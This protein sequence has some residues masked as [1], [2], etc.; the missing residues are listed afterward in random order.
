MNNLTQLDATIPATAEDLARDLTTLATSPGNSPAP[1]L[2]TGAPV[3]Q[4][5]VITVNWEGTRVP[6]ALR[7]LDLE[8][9]DDMTGWV[10]TN[11][12]GRSFK[13]KP[14]RVKMGPENVPIMV[15]ALFGL[16]PERVDLAVEQFARRHRAARNFLPLFLVDSTDTLLLR[17]YGY[18]FEYF[19]PEVYS[20]EHMAD[21]F[22]RRF[23]QI[24]K[25]WRCDYL[26]DL[27]TPGYLDARIE[28]L[29]PYINPPA[30][31]TKRYD[32]RKR[33]GSAPRPAPT[34][35][36]ALK[37]DYH[38]SG[39]VSEPDTFVL[40]RILG[41]DLPPRH[42]VGQT[43]RNLRFLLENE[44]PLEGCEKRWII[45]R[46]VNPEQEAAIIALLEEFDQPYLSIPFLY[47]EYA[48]ADWDLE[49]FPDTP[50]F[51]RGRY[52]EM[53]SYDQLRAQAHL[54][55]LK[56]NYL[57]HNNGARNV[58]LRDGKDRA[59]WVL[60]W[61][62]NCFISAS[63]WAEITQTVTAQSYLKYFTVPMSRALDNADLLNTDYR[64][65]AEEE[66]QMLFRRDTTEEF[67]ETF[68]YG[69]RPKVELF[70]RL[71]IPGPWDTWPDDVWDLPRAAR[72]EDAGA[73][74]SAGWVARL[75]SGQGQLEVGQNVGL[76]SRG[77]ARISAIT[78][79]LDRLD[80]EALKLVYRPE[81]LTAYDEDKVKALADAE[82]G[83]SER[84]VHDRL[85]QEAELALQRGPYSVADK[86]AT[87]PSGDK[88]DYF[89]PAPYWWPN[90]A[91]PTG[92]P[93][94]FRDGLRIPGTRLY[95]PESDLYDRTRVQKLFD[96]S[97]TL[98]LAWLLTGK[99][100]YIRHAASLVRHWF[101]TEQTRMN[102]HLLYSQVRSQSPNDHGSK[103]GLIE[104]KDLYY[105]LDAVR[106]VERSGEF[107]VEDQ[108]AMRTWLSEYAEWLETSDQGM[109]EHA[110]Q[111]NHG[112]CLDL[113]KAAIAAFVND[114]E[115]L[116][117]IFRTSRERMLEQFKPD[118]LQPHEM[119]RTQTAHY[120]CFNL[121]NWINL[122]NLAEACGDRLWHFEAEDGRGLAAAF[123]WLLPRLA[124]TQWKYEQI[125]P[126]DRSRFLPLFYEA[127]G[128]APDTDEIE[129]T[130][131]AQ[132][133]PLF[134]PHDGIKPFWMLGKSP[135][136]R[137]G[138]RSWFDLAAGL[139]RL[140]VAA[141]E[142]V[143]PNAA[144]PQDVADVRALDKRLWGGF[145]QDARAGLEA[146][147]DDPATDPKEVNRAARS[148]ARW[149]FASGDMTAAL[150]AATTIENVGVLAERE[151]D[152]LRAYCLHTLGEGEASGEIVT[153]LLH[154][155]PRDISLNF[156]MANFAGASSAPAGTGA[157]HWV[158]GIYRRAGLADLVDADGAFAR[159]Q[160]GPEIPDPTV[161]IVSVILTIRAE[162]Q[163]ATTA[164]TSL[165]QQTWR[166]LDIIL[167]DQT[168]G[169]LDK[170]IT[171]EIASDDRVTVIAL[172]PDEPTFA[173]RN[174]A[175]DIAKGRYVTVHRADEWAHPEKLQRLVSLHKNDEPIVSIAQ[176]AMASE[177]GEFFAGWFP[178][179][180]F[181]APNPSSMMI[182]IDM[183]RALGGWDAVAD[184]LDTCLRWRIEKS[185]G[186]ASLKL[187]A[188][189]PPLSVTIT[190]G[191]PV[192]P[193]H[194]GFPAG[195]RRDE[196]RR[197][198][199]HAKAI[200]A[201]RI[202]P[203]ETPFVIPAMPPV[204]SIPSA[205]FD[206]VYVGDFAAGSIAVGEIQAF[207]ERTLATDEKA[208]LFHWTDK[209]IDRPDELEDGIADLIDTGR[210]TQ[211]STYEIVSTKL[212]VIC[213]P[214]LLRAPVD[215]VPNFQPETIAVLGGPEFIGVDT[216]DG[217]FRMTPTQAELEVI[218]D[219]S[220]QWMTL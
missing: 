48:R 157:A 179:F 84:Y 141:F 42:E 192:G 125:E 38:A 219:T 69:R 76:R 5:A 202:P 100:D 1:S 133:K 67:N 218:L 78:Q 47:E 132:G 61:D 196:L 109:D 124:R 155:F 12:P 204:A 193:T 56:N 118:G 55:R 128:R 142:M 170:A 24:W 123:G 137:S 164:F 21:Q 112:T 162:D 30:L 34:D 197:L 66:P 203:R 77:E 135:M 145:S 175:L 16:T 131:A 87:P 27:S 63:A 7:T 110:T 206:T 4:D 151:R 36:I 143:S 101:I 25:K 205:S 189:A 35:V 89:N 153:G 54:R 15:V 211:I 18:T 198:S 187:V 83:T 14:G 94:Q 144:P 65:D 201:D 29:D 122:C 86:G 113:Q 146:L 41:N 130:R 152:L 92:M 19:P 207:I 177:G 52:A 80:V 115:R 51:L 95:E 32:P 165:C 149:S 191:T 58:A 17:D 172:A 114:P 22:L 195:R 158:N 174:A 190:P 150:E 171:A 72:S 127:R 98:S 116:H 119:K 68:Y 97:T 75:F 160:T 180:S 181:V 33:R 134:F 200:R 173:A 31:N 182:P 166:A 183:V 140:E 104:M 44:P 106:L 212:L 3:P 85:I 213:H 62:G 129:L 28:D 194:I 50:F 184:N 96:D 188:A 91:T 99:I 167:V 64:P 117:D 43:L 185:F 209:H 138:S 20:S 8:P 168:D 186:V 217:K 37:A 210:L 73:T 6:A 102:P 154:Q 60:P 59:K 93:F 220:F 10:D 46:V 178:E 156:A 161:P 103:S 90:P 9:E 81:T 120:C 82:D 70:Y 49:S 23:R 169:H 199:R 57:I 208:G 216:M 13:P 147:R 53:N 2:A 74:G 40:Y 39:L 159:Y 121:Q 88:Q 79:M 71:G 11:L 176:L 215:G 163:H 136:E 111:N 126:F 45:N 139:K 108:S 26:I 105:F 148:L 107:G 214:H